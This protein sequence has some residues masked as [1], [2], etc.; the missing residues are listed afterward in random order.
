M[1][2][3]FQSGAFIQQCF[4]SH[5][6]CLTLKKL[7]LPEKILLA[8]TSCNMLHRLTVRALTTHV[9]AV[10][11]ASE[12]APGGD[13]AA[14]CLKH[15]LAAHQVALGVR[16]VDVLRDSVGLRCAECRRLYDLDVA[17]FETHQR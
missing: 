12:E 9:P 10:R 16:E 13:E 4:A 14:D 5:R 15:C 3:T 11:A 1:A 2:Q 17:A 8:C 6:L 7:A